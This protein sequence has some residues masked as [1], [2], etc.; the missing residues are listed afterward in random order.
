[1]QL[2]ALLRQHGIPVRDVHIYTVR[3][4]T[5]T[6]ETAKEALETLDYL[7]FSSAGGVERYF[8][9][10]GAVPEGTVCVCI[11]SVTA[12]AL[13]VRYQKPFLTAASISAEGIAETIQ[14]HRNTHGGEM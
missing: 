2:P 7:A 9:A 6:A 1:M 13:R 3:T 12:A 8:A 10:H 14:M 11:G 4:D 5:E